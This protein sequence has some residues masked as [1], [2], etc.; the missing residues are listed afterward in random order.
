MP[1]DPIFES[2]SAAPSRT[3]GRRR[4]QRD[5][6]RGQGSPDRYDAFED[7]PSDRQVLE[8]LS[9]SQESL[10]DTAVIRARPPA[11]L[12]RVARSGRG[13]VPIAIA[14][15]DVDKDAV[16]PSDRVEEIM[17]DGLRD[18]MALPK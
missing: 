11:A 8:S 14:W 4:E 3:T 17:P 1:S 9:A 18:R 2:H 10:P 16:E 6:A 13:G 15:I 12:D 7:V 5:R